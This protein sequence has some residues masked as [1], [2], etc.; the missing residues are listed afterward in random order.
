MINR[1]LKNDNSNT[2]GPVSDLEKHLPEDWWKTLFNSLYIKTDGDVVE[3][4]QNT[5]Q[6]VDLLINKLNIE[7]NHHILDLCTGS[8]CIAIACAYAFEYAAIDAVELNDDALANILCMLFTLDTSH[9][10]TS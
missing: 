4:D 2:L 5:K 9:S 10:L 7:T 3:N 1:T 6:D 8:A